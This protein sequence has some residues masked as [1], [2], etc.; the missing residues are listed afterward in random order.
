MQKKEISLF[1]VGTFFSHG[2]GEF[3]EGNHST[4]PE[5]LGYRKILCI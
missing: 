1:S 3:G 4:F 2:A 5:I